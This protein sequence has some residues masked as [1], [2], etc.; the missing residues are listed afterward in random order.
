MFKQRNG[1]YIRGQLL[2]GGHCVVVLTMCY[3]LQCHSR[4]EVPFGWPAG[5]GQSCHGKGLKAVRYS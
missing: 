3:S 2:A 5:A 4:P 1:L